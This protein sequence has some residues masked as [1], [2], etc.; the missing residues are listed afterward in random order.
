[1]K[2]FWFC[3][4]MFFSISAFALTE[5]ITLSHANVN[6][7]DT[8]SIKRGAKYFATICIACHTLIYMRYDPIA[9]EAGITYEKMPINITKWP[10]NVKPPD[11]SLETE[12]HSPDWVYTYLHSFY[13]D[14]STATG[15]NN[16]IFPDTAMPDMLASF[17]GTQTLAGDIIQSE[18]SYGHTLEWYDVV[19][20]QQQGSKTPDEFDQMTLD[21]VNFL[22]YAAEP[23]AVKQE[24][25]GWWVLGY[26]LILLVLVVLMKRAYW[27]GERA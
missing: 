15:F 4:L 9:I 12:V 14:K 1:V 25:L 22:N 10:N 5:E 21:I 26:L 27:K 7:H 3:L 18:G 24:Q 19:E 17:Q 20:L 16:L 6:I 8:A 23:F 13:V 2:H 11:L